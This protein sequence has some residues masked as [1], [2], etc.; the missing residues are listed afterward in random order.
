MEKIVEETNGCYQY[1]RETFPPFA[2]EDEMHIFF[3]V[4]IIL[5]LVSGYRTI[6]DIY[7][8]P[9]FGNLMLHDCFL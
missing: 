7:K 1:I 4:V 9:I 2:S 3:Y 5:L 8:M 6:G